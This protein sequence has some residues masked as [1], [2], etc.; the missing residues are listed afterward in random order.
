MSD[1]LTAPATVAEVIEQVTAIQPLLRTN[2]AEGEQLR[3]VP[4]ESIDALRAAGAFRV[5]TPKRYGGLEGTAQDMLDVSAAAAYGDG[6]AGW[7]V[8]L[9]NVCGW[10]AGLMSRQLQ[11]E[12]WGEDPDGFVTGVLAPTAQ[13]VR[14][15]GGYRVTGKWYYNSGSDHSTWA[16]VGIPIPN[17]AGEI[18][19]QGLA[20]IPRSDYEI[21][22]TWFV[23]ACD[24]A[25][26]TASS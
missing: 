15:E 14:V 11:D 20:M 12:I 9:A 13:A 21:E 25:G 26:A 22:D 6:G 8:T 3:Q 19:N 17:E 23:A 4:A 24:R 10:L 7:V 5:G 18:V 16:G 1:T 2:A